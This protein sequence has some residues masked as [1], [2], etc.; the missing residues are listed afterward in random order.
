[1]LAAVGRLPSASILT[2]FPARAGTRREPAEHISCA[3][4]LHRARDPVCPWSMPQPVPCPVASDV[5]R[6]PAMRLSVKRH[7][8]ASPEPLASQKRLP[9]AE[10]EADHTY[11]RIPTVSSIKRQK[12][13]NTKAKAAKKTK[14][15]PPAPQRRSSPGTATGAIVPRP[16]GRVLAHRCSSCESQVIVSSQGVGRKMGH[17]V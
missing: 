7:R 8:P 13:Q 9:R 12:S 14:E 1:M 10:R 5:V 17:G 2:P 4:F 6:S 3:S 16:L 15:R 11:S